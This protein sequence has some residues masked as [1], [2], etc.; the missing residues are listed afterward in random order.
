MPA[1]V[2]RTAARRGFVLFSYGFRP[3]FLLAGIY[4]AVPAATTVAV[5]AGG[6]WP[7]QAPPLFSWHGHEMLFGFASAAVAGFL[8]TAVPTWTGTKAVSGFALACLVLLWLAGRIV[9]SPWVAPSNLFPQVL[10]VAFFP[11]LASTVAVPLIRTKNVRNLPFILL[12]AILFLGDFASQSSR[13]GWTDEPLLDGLRLAINTVTLMIVI[14][15]GRIIPAFTRN[16]LKAMRRESTMRSQRAIDIASIAVVAAVLL[17]D[18]LAPDSMFAGVLAAFSAALLLIRL[19][20][21]GGLR[22]LDQPLLWV[23]H[24]GYAWL[25][26]AFALKALWLLD[27]SI[28]AAS[29]LH[30]FTAGAFGTMIMGVMTRVALGHTGRR[31]QIGRAVTASYVLVSAAA[32]ARV[33]GAS[34]AGA[35][36]TEVL[37]VS[38]LAWTSAFAIFLVVYAPILIGPR[39]D[40]NAG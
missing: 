22:V 40:G 19:S 5:L 6:A 13:Y 26:L 1:D 24:V 21:W 29:W 17:G 4:A 28:W 7:Q 11:A 18:V 33:F 16:A 14:I 32:L 3:F 36:Y 30:A 10:A 15:G 35:Y 20:G 9:S 25:A 34:A 38:V 2:P 27:G 23:L 37:A 31:L 39:V 8:L 12:L